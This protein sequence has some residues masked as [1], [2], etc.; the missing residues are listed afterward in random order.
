MERKGRRMALNPAA[1]SQRYQCAS[2]GFIS[3]ILEHSRRNKP[4]YSWG[5]QI[6]MVALGE[7]SG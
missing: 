7:R 1:H 4:S 3:R 2:K 5:S 6:E